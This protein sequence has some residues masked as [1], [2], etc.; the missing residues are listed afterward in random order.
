MFARQ[1]DDSGDRDYNPKVAANVLNSLVE[2]ATIPVYP[3]EVVI[4]ADAQELLAFPFLFMTA[5]NR[6]GSPAWSASA[7][8]G[9]LLFSGDDDWRNERFQRED[10][11]SSR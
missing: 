8:R 4:A 9:G 6:S 2:Y 10:T 1:R 7:S 3:E 5:T 11:R